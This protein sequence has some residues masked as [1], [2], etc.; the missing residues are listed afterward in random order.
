MIGAYIR[1]SSSR[2]GEG[3][4]PE[5]QRERLQTAGAEEFYVDVVS[6]F[7][8]QQRR[9]ATEFERLVADIKAGRLTKLLTTRLDRIVRRDAIFM[10]LAELCDKQHVEFLSLGSGRVNT[11]TASGWLEVKVQLMMAEH[12][13]RQLSENVRNGLAAQ[14]ARGVHTR[15]STALPFHLAPDPDTRR[16]VIPGEA[17]DDARH[18]VDQILAGR[19]TLSDS[20]R[21]IHQR[22]GRM[23]A[24]SSFSRWLKSPAILGHACDEHGRIQIAACWPALVNETEH[25]RL[26]ATV[27][28]ARKR[29]GA[30]KASKLPPKALSGLCFCKYCGS[31]MA[32]NTC[33]VGKYTYEYIRCYSRLGCSVK[34]KNIPALDIEQM[35]IIE[36]VMPRMESII[37]ATKRDLQQDA[38]PL[39]E[40]KQWLRE[41]RHRT[42]TPPEFLMAAD[43]ERINELQILIARAS[44][45][46]AAVDTP[47]L[48]ALALKLTNATL[49]AASSWF[50]DPPPIRNENL[51][52][53]LQSITIDAQTKRIASATFRLANA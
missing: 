36:H 5:N 3:E 34:Y 20:A 28:E 18:C 14:L 48:A 33:R 16:G 6:G 43:R 38:A 4:S 53:L 19:W 22:H 23:V 29:W 9:K 24:T 35:L 40:K 26:L 10:E 30:N 45:P 50:S 8:L 47:D 17:W 37:N 51:K 13:S 25:D 31:G 42:Q 21:F 1:V 44:E 27:A 7:R 2:Q 39:P 52:A 32:I 12:Y 41:L 46:I 11:T 49:G 15:P